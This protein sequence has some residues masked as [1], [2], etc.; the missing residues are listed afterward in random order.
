MFA[1]SKY[2]VLVIVGISTALL[3]FIY[4]VLVD[5]REF[6]LAQVHTDEV[7]TDGTTEYLLTVSDSV[8]LDDIER[9]LMAT[10]LRDLSREFRDAVNSFKEND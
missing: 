9:D 5:R 10:E 8:K 4:L 3:A 2:V 7:I 6:V 1:K